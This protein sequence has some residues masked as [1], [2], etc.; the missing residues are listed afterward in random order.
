MFFKMKFFYL[1]VLIIFSYQFQNDSFGQ[2]NNSKLEYYPV[3]QKDLM[4]S[5]IL[6]ESIVSN[7]KKTVNP[8]AR[9]ESVSSALATQKNVL[10]GFVKRINEEGLKEWV[11]VC[12][13][14]SDKVYFNVVL[15]PNS[16]NGGVNFVC[17]FSNQQ[18]KEK[19]SNEVFQNLK[20]YTKPELVKFTI[21]PLESEIIVNPDQT[22]IGLNLKSSFI[23]PIVGNIVVP[24]EK[25]K[26]FSFLAFKK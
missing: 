2:K 10:T 26:S 23:N 24:P 19:L 20:K 6:A 12:H 13:V 18:Q 25:L 15:N 8:I 5:V 21:D 9:Q 3:E 14:E 17:G 22:G 4:R 16:R 7:A 11:A 1:V